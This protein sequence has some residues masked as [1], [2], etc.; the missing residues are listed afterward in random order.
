ME[1]IIQAQGIS[2]YADA[3]GTVYLLAEQVARGL[4]FVQTKGEVEFV[5]WDRIKKLL[6][7]FG[8]FDNHSEVQFDTHKNVYIPEQYFYLLA[9]K[10]TNDTAK[11]FQRKLAFDVI[12][13]IRRCGIYG[14]ISIEKLKE[15]FTEKERERQIALI[16]DKTERELAKRNYEL[17]NYRYSCADVAY[18]L[19][20]R[21]TY[22]DIKPEGVED[23]VKNSK[24]ARS[25]YKYDL[26]SDLRVNENGLRHLSRFVSINREIFAKM[27]DGCVM[28]NPKWK[29]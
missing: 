11:A 15:L 23:L 17:I 1:T 13:T 8:Y 10:A 21:Y 4:G 29:Y 28:T 27:K 3:D 20:K 12:P 18:N 16:E 19:N 22:A 24:M 7:D 26:L 25:S 14:S 5:R 6:E 2:G 9:M